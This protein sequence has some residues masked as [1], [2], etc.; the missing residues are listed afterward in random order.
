MKPFLDENF[1]LTNKTAERLYHDYA[2]KMPI[3]DYHCHIDPKEIALDRR[4]ENITQIWLG[5]DH[6]KWRLMR[7]NGVD[8]YYITGNASD[9]EKF[10]KW[11][12]T[13]S[14]AI[15]NPLYHWSHLE[16]QRYFGYKGLLN[17]NTAKE[18]WDLC[19]KKLADSSMSVRNIIKNSRVTHIC[20]TDDPADSL[21]WHDY[22]VN[23]PDFDVNVYP[24]WRPDRAMNIEKYDYL[25]YL[26]KLSN[27]S[28]ERIDSFASLK[29]A[30][31]NRMEFFHSKKCRISDHG[32]DYIMYVPASEET[33]DKIFEKR[34]KGQSLSQ[35]EIGQFKTAF[36]VFVGKEYHKLG[37]VMQLHYGCRRSN[38]TLAFQKLGP[39]TGFDC[40]NAYSSASEMA[41]FLDALNKSNELPKTIVYSLNP[42]ENAMIDSIIACFQDSSAIGKLQHGSAW[43]FNDHKTGMEEQ[44]ISLANLGYLANFVG[45]LT[46]SRSFLS[47]SR[48][49]YFRRILCNLIGTWVENGEYPQDFT[50]LGEIV[51]DICYKNALRYF[52]F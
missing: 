51:Q 42:T 34:L 38:N 50:T 40:I 49:E 6:Y 26:M 31:K 25:D 3:L 13:I 52:N 19:N 1:L 36:M 18:V 11:A 32:L 30:L 27:V 10:E 28:N 23:D 9:W 24:S 4:Y 46:D 8:E 39:D 20:T 21:K 44:L 37:W 14:K 17:K 16:L 41:E 45:M 7:A 48:H 29:K 15:G 2:D 22:I 12:E 5:G 35:H 43:W 33:I 47:Y